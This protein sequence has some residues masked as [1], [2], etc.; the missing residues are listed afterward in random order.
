MFVLLFLPQCLWQHG[1]EAMASLGSSHLPLQSWQEWCAWCHWWD[2]QLPLQPIQSMSASP[3]GLAWC[4]IHCPVGICSRE[5]GISYQP[6][7]I[8]ASQPQ[9]LRAVW[10]TLDSLVPVQKDAAVWHLVF[11]IWD[12][13][14]MGLMS[15]VSS[16][17][18]KMCLTTELT[19]WELCVFSGY[20]PLSYEIDNLINVSGLYSG[21]M[22]V[23]CSKLSL[24]VTPLVLIRALGWPGTN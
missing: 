6:S 11:C 1:V 23:S 4:L 2:G 22:S 19:L 18:P 17:T 14:R 15:E 20:K 3:S 7:G 8:L 12:F 10:T 24:L 21:Y 9:S 13:R 5:L 16:V